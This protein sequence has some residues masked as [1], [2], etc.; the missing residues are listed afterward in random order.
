MICK[1][2]MPATAAALLALALSVPFAAASTAIKVI[3]TGEGGDAMALSIEPST[4]K[5]GDAVFSV[6]N[7]AATE[8]HEMILVKLKAPDQAIP[9][10]KAKHR[11]DES[12]LKSLGEV[13]DLKPGKD[14]SLQ[15]KLE[16]GTY[17]LFCNIKGHYEAGMKG[18]L[19]VTE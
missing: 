1:F 3:E 15:A 19:T 16:P 9:V 18:M 5:A 7:G 14:G 17:L 13:S 12:K 6:H 2:R 4:V 11:V 8:N 10:V